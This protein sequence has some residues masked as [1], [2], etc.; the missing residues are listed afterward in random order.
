[1][2]SERRVGRPPK[3]DLGRLAELDNERADQRYVHALRA[4]S[5][6]SLIVTDQRTRDTYYVS[7]PIE[8]T[9][10]QALSAAHHYAQTRG[11]RA[12]ETITLP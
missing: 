9:P 12:W 8:W 11:V 1:M 2:N 10:A 3:E 4:Q 7:F 5:S 6:G